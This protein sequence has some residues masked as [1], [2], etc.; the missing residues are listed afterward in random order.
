MVFWE[1]QRLVWVGVVAVV[2]IAVVIV[3]VAEKR[4]QRLDVQVVMGPWWWSSG[5]GEP[6]Q[7][8]EGW[9]SL[10]KIVS[11]LFHP[12]PEEEGE[13]HQTSWVHEMASSVGW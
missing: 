3:V 10:L 11:I 8:Q 2:L 1:Q 4:G 12:R 5:E 13:G 6:V 7:E 9:L